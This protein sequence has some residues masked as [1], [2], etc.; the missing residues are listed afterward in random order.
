M[1]NYLAA[2]LMDVIFQGDDLEMDKLW[3]AVHWTNPTPEGNLSTEVA[4]GNYVRQ[5]VGDT[6]MW[7]RSSNSTTVLTRPVAFL[8]MP[9]GV[10]RY[11]AL[12]N[13]PTSG[14]G[15]GVMMWYGPLDKDYTV[16]DG[17]TFSLPANSVAVA[18][19]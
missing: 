19:S 13:A 16:L 18:L 17:Q 11:V 1:S 3:L 10:V 4:G 5:Y 14:T 9:S 7:S 15:T 6:G 8:G 12:W 2:L